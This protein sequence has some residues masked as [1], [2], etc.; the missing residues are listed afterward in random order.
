MREG[1][2]QSLS[3]TQENAAVPFIPAVPG[4]NPVD[5]LFLQSSGE[6]RVRYCPV[7]LTPWQ[8]KMNHIHF[9]ILCYFL[10]SKTF[11]V[12]KSGS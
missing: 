1:D 3:V 8:R 12:D 6:E 9:N 10:L 2:R 11:L 5:A 4:L 7:V